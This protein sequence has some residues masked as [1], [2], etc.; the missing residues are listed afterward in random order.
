MNAT[1]QFLGLFTIIIKERNHVFCIN[2]SE[3][4]N[5]SYVGCSCILVLL[6]VTPFS[7]HWHNFSFF[8]YVHL[9]HCC[10]ALFTTYCDCTYSLFKIMLLYYSNGYYHPCCVDYLLFCLF[11]HCGTYFDLVVPTKMAKT[12]TV[13]TATMTKEYKAGNVWCNWYCFH[14]VTL[15]AVDNALWYHCQHKIATRRQIKKQRISLTLSEFSSF[16]CWGDFRSQNCNPIQNENFQTVILVDQN[17]ACKNLVYKRESLRTQLKG[18]TRFTKIDWFFI[19]V[20]LLES[21]PILGWNPTFTP[22]IWMRH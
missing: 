19:V 11:C 8:A 20:W 14:C 13:M 16:L 7:T 1:N 6:H 9:V 18:A 17:K 5:G 4:G 3:Y 22:L 12:A 10:Q 2:E 21:H 15:A